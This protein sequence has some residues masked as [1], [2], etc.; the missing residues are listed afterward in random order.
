MIDFLKRRGTY[1]FFWFTTLVVAYILLVFI[2]DG[3]GFERFYLGFL[4]FL[5]LPFFGYL[6][7]EEIQY[8]KLM[9]RLENLKYSFEK[10]GMGE[11]NVDLYFLNSK[12]RALYKA[13]GEIISV[14]QNLYVDSKLKFKRHKTGYTQWVHD[15]K[16]PLASLHLMLH[17]YESEL[18][19]EFLV[20]L[21]LIILQMDSL[22]EQ[23]LYMEKLDYLNRDFMVDYY[24]LKPLINQ[25]IKKNH[26]LF[27]QKKIKL[28][29]EVE[30][31]SVLTDEK[32]LKYVV[33]Q[34][35]VNSIKY[36]AQGGRVSL[37]QWED[38]DYAF[39][40][41]RDT[42]EGIKTE[43]I[44]R[45]FDYGFTGSNGRTEKA[46]SGIGLYLAKEMCGHLGHELWVDAV[47][48]E[49]SCFNIKMKK[50]KTSL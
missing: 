18:S 1:L 36:T 43:E 48:G 24:P 42:G 26:L 2:G 25:V 19:E 41:I 37:K 5:S 29:I 30:G 45:V 16:I 22:L 9:K 6:I 28:E 11:I 15:I 32:W 10:L 7:I 40:A 38:A 44:P 8:K 33:E 21:N 50:A 47:I 27:L 23:Q 14:L 4:F 31:V 34:I 49:G 46:S 12:S 39:L 20:E 17:N 13:F 35:I 3:T